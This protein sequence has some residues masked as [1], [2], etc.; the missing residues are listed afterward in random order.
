[1]FS[2][3]VNTIF[4]LRIRA[5][6]NQ[7]RKVLFFLISIVSVY[8]SPSALWAATDLNKFEMYGAISTMLS[9]SLMISIPGL[10]WR[11]CT[12]VVSPETRHKTLF[13]W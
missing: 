6:Y 2:I 12:M 8:I 7:S 1:M 5:L 9:S 3:I 13:A 4:V 11:G 10:T